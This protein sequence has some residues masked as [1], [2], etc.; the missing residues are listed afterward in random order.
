MKPLS[1][2]EIQEAVKIWEK[3]KQRL[4]LYAQNFK[5]NTEGLRSTQEILENLTEV[6]DEIDQLNS[7]DPEERK[8]INLL[9]K[10]QY[11]LEREL[12]KWRIP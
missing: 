11:E 1:K 5:P 9:K 8:L 10:E 3:K 6:H 12:E 2:E 4:E 7:N